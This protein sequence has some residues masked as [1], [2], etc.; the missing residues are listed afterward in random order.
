MQYVK[1]FIFSNTPYVS[2]HF[3][4]NFRN[5]KAPDPLRDL[6]MDPCLQK[7]T[8]PESML[9]KEKAS[10]AAGKHCSHMAEYVTPEMFEK[11]K[12]MVSGGNGNWT[13]ARAINTGV[14]FPRAYMG[15]H[16]GDPQSYD[17]FIDIYKPC[18]ERY[19]TGFKWDA[20]HAHRTDLNADNLEGD[21]TDLAKG[22]V[23]STRIRVARNLDKPFV[24]SPNGTAETRKAVLSMVRQ[25][26]E[27]FPPELAGTLYAHADMTAAEERKLIDDHILFKGEDARQAAAG[28]HRFWPDGRGVFCSTDKT[29]NMWVNEG[30]HLRIMCLFLNSDVPGVLRKLSTGIAAME[31]AIS[32][33]TGSS[34]PIASHP[35][36][37]CITC[38]P[39]NLGTG[40]RASVM[41][42]LPNLT[43]KLGLHGI[44]A[45][46][47]KNH[48]QARGSTG[49]FS[50]VT[51]GCRCD[52]SNRY[53]LGYSEVELVNQMI[54]T[55]NLLAEEEVKAGY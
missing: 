19:H 37:G 21:L 1:Q 18:V 22:M 31:A 2:T 40:C 49:E 27:T 28:Y 26:V 3:P 14:M 11:Y 39:T 45:I 43:K 41:M 48:C 55:A 13:F 23:V 32:K 35:I 5:M 12:D 50:E 9:A 33:V 42:D 25:C 52:I 53:R 24:M 29:F 47:A 6:I 20:E 30:D 17:T 36:L 44:D 15:I 34:T 4:S 10:L 16:A 51:E 8:Y 54:R 7:N 46:C 38:C